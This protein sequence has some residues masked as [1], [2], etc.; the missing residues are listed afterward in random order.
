MSDQLD[1]LKRV[2]DALRRLTPTAEDIAAAA[3][4]GGTPIP[5]LEFGASRR[6]AAKA[7]RGRHTAWTRGMA[8]PVRMFLSAETGGAALLVVAIAAALIWTNSPWSSSYGSFWSKAVSISVA[9]HA[10][11]IDLRSAVNQGLMTLFFLVVGLEAKRELDLGELRDRR[12]LTVPVL[13]G[14]GGIGGSITVYLIVTAGHAGVGGWGVAASSD[15]ALA[16][17][18]LTLATGNRGNRLRVFLLTVLVVDDLVALLI[19][20]LV[21]PAHI[22]PSAL[23]TSA[24]LLTALLGMRALGVRVRENPTFGGVLFALSVLDGIALWVALYESGVDPVIS[25]LFIG[26]VT[27]AYNPRRPDIEH[28]SQLVRSFREQPT[29]AA[30]YEARASLTGAISPNERLQ[31][32]LHPWTSRVIVPIF[33]LANAGLHLNGTVISA[34]L[35]SPVTWA[36]VIAFVAGK[37]AGIMFAAW[38]TAKGA[39]RT[40]KLPVS[41]AELFGTASATGVGFTASLL[42]ASRAFHGSLLSQAKVGILATVIISPLV[43][44]ISFRPLR[45]RDERLGLADHAVPAADLTVDVDPARD[46]IRGDV[47][48]PITLLI[49]VSFGREYCV[50]ASKAIPEILERF[51][52]RVRLVVRLLPLVDVIPNAQLAAAAVEAAGDQ[53]AFWEMHDQLI[54]EDAITLSSVFRSAHR[55]G[56]DL[57]RFFDDI[58]KQDER[59]A[60][61]VRSADASGVI[62]TPAAFINGHRYEGLLDAVALT[63]ALTPLTPVRAPATEVTT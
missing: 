45:R 28:G 11:T 30:A 43:S 49:Y 61:D 29:P 15:T 18:A 32:R 19:I 46:H 51:A 50:A 53:D 24:F 7:S 60:A 17:G 14:L 54:R 40:G 38:S 31:Y 9:G 4:A 44:A 23:A 42:I 8:A 25:G 58:D 37:P 62:G 56:L 59:I 22:D 1:L 20:A 16:L 55:I 36:I 3:T 34:A 6:W 13:A 63:A 52:G 27:T 57:P 5:L 21:Y 47:N 35:S 12:R 39:P 26:L 48:A 41:W 2:R 33:A 10:L